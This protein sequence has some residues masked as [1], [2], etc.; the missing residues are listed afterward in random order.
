MRRSFNVHKKTLT[1]PGTFSKGGE[2]LFSK[3]YL[4]MPLLELGERKTNL[5]TN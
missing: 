3:K 5:D 1:G 2:N 4:Y